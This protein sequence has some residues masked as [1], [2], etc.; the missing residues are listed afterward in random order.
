[1]IRDIGLLLALTF[2]GIPAYI[3]LT[4]FNDNLLTIFIAFFF[5]LPVVLLGAIISILFGAAIMLLPLLFILALFFGLLNFL[6]LVFD[7]RGD[8]GDEGTV[9]E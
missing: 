9:T 2:F 1:M 8:S 7:L 4:L 3:A 6:R 5:F